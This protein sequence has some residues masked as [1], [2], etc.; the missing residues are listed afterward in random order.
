MG[1]G[2]PGQVTVWHMVRVIHPMSLHGVEW[3]EVPA[4]A[5]LKEPHD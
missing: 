3:R 4:R 5:G 2:V 1:T